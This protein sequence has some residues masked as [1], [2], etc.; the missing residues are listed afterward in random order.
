[1]HASLDGLHR[2][3]TRSLGFTFC[4]C[5]CCYFWFFHI[6]GLSQ[7]RALA[8]PSG[9]PVHCGASAHLGCWLLGGETVSPSLTE[10]VGAPR[11]YTGQA[12]A[13]VPGWADA[14]GRE[15]VMEQIRGAHSVQTG[16]ETGESTRCEAQNPDSGD[17]FDGA[18]R[19]L[20]LLLRPRGHRGR[21]GEP[22][23][24][25]KPPRGPDEV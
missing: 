24:W 15:L 20:V 2:L 6:L 22:E 8:L 12:G 25:Q 17:M 10:L 3:G 11:G 18:G 9:Y 1:M 23:S 7:R 14:H 19:P 21:A 5:R 16:K 13:Q 4:S